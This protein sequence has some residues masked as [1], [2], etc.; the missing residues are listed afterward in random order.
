MAISASRHPLPIALLLGMVAAQTAVS[1][2]TSVGSTVLHVEPHDVT[3]AGCSV[4]GDPV[5]AESGAIVP[6]DR[7]IG[8]PEALRWEPAPLQHPP[9]VSRALGLSRVHSGP[10]LRMAIWGDSHMVSG[11]FR[12]ELAHALDGL[13]Y[14]VEQAALPLSFVQS[15]TGLP[16]HG[17]CIR[18]GDWI[19]HPAYVLKRTAAVGPS[20]A[21]LRPARS[22][23]TLTLD[24]RD[25]AGVRVRRRVTLVYT[26]HGSTG[27]LIRLRVDGGKPI[28]RL[29]EPEH[30]G[31]PPVASLVLESEAPLASLQIDALD[32]LFELQAV[33]LGPGSSS[34][35]T[36]DV[37]GI[38]SST[39]QGWAIAD[40]EVLRGMLTPFGY[41]VVFMAYGTNEAADDRF[42]M[43]SYRADLRVALGNFRRVFPHQECF[44]IGPPDRGVPDTRGSGA[45][46]RNALRYAMRHQQVASVQSQVSAEF[47][48]GFWNWQEAMGGLG[49]SYQW[50]RASGLMA[51][52][53]IH[54]SLAGYRA[55][56]AA[57]ARSLGWSRPMTTALP[58]FPSG[59]AEA[60]VK[61]P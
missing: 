40:P 17:I 47:G 5:S 31:G 13:G 37:Y 38:N 39:A 9:R 49:S 8:L 61:R 30:S 6:G 11:A 25:R 53:L 27:A 58:E 28:Y 2:A 43:E 4:V 1:G 45:A 41:D 3:L 15:A 56:A 59:R 52:D 14:T 32:D 55:S 35:V 57:L 51:P 20:L 42:D 48:C 29:L 18:P 26:P 10:P 50:S 33:W 44:L 36:L 7:S 54:F 12:D 60:G 21:S 46:G 24:L 19:L 22:G 16:L 23:S 34:A